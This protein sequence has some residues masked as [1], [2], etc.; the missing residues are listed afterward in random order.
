ML[1]GQRP[2]KC[3]EAIILFFKFSAAGCRHHHLQSVE[4]TLWSTN[5]AMENGPFED[6]FPIEHGDFAASHVSLLEFMLSFWVRTPKTQPFC[7]GK[8]PS[9][10][11]LGVFNSTHQLH[12]IFNHYLAVPL[13]TH[14]SGKNVDSSTKFYSI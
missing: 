6:V 11:I 9:F 5:M 1:P 10:P 12:R 14:H 2:P 3:H 4:F 8:C 13:T 7:H